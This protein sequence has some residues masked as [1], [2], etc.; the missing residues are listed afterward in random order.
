MMI[1]IQVFQVLIWEIKDQCRLKRKMRI[2]IETSRRNYSHVQM[3][4]VRSDWCYQVIHSWK[5]R[6]YTRVHRVQ[7]IINA[8]RKWMGLNTL[9]ELELY[10]K[11]RM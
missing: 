5:E 7:E 8:M 3:D 10:G 11:E 6:T 2:N 1:K 9:N 4:I